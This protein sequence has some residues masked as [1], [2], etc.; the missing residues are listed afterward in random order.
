MF[1][2]FRLLTTAV[3]LY[4]VTCGVHRSGASDSG[5]SGASVSGAS[6]TGDTN[7]SLQDVVVTLA[8]VTDK[9]HVSTGVWTALDAR[10]RVN[11][12]RTP[13]GN[14]SWRPFINVIEVSVYA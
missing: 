10:V 11:T 1:V 2:G 12:P 7:G 9:D 5:A 6:D 4:S 14:E 3:L 8:E 13:R